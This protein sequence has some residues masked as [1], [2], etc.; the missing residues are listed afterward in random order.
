MLYSDSGYHHKGMFTRVP[1]ENPEIRLNWKLGYLCY[2]HN[3]FHWD[4]FGYI[5][6]EESWKILEINKVSDLIPLI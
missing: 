6:S 2:G 5:T 4:I 1:K 3:I